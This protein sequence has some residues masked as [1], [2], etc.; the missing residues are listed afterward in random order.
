MKIPKYASRG[1]PGI[2]KSYDFRGSRF[3]RT[4][5]DYRGERRHV[6]C[7]ARDVTRIAGR[8][9]TRIA[10]LRVTSPAQLRSRVP[11]PISNENFFFPLKEKKKFRV[12]R[13]N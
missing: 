1:V 2:I 13:I 11:A 3:M 10:N 4:G 5:I 7:F 8:D 6:V 9:V 12:G